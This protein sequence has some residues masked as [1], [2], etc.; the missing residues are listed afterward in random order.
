MV[1]QS[2]QEGRPEGGQEGKQ[3]GR[4]GDKQEGWKVNRKAERWKGMKIGV[5]EGRKLEV[6]RLVLER[7]VVVALPAV[8]LK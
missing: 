6:G 7:H 1:G 2:T 3:E 5:E 8:Y 4:Q